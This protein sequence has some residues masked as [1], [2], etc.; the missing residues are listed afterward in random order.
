M[1][2][3]VIVTVFIAMCV[4][5]YFNMCVCFGSC[6]VSSLGM[7]LDVSLTCRDHF[8]LSHVFPCFRV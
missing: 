6:L 2:L 4:C 5:V 8:D 3:R 1:Q 7:S